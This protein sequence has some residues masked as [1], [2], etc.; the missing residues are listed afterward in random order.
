MIATITHTLT[1]GDWLVWSALGLFCVLFITP[2]RS[3]FRI[4]LGLV[5]CGPPGWLFLLLYLGQA[6]YSES[7]SA[8]SRM[9]SRRSPDA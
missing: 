1:P 9:R 7:S 5:L 6:L 2:D 8:L 3:L 4:T